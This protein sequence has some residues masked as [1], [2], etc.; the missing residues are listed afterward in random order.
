M[1]MA[2]QRDASRI[3]DELVVAIVRKVLVAIGIE[4][5]VVKEDLPDGVHRMEKQL[6][7]SRELI[8]RQ[9]ARTTRRMAA[10]DALAV[11]ADRYRETVR[12][13]KAGKSART[14]LFDAVDEWREIP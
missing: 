5:A 3:P 14:K 9:T 4:G 2:G 7:A 1:V 6:E 13:G 12:K 8:A 10:L 11:A